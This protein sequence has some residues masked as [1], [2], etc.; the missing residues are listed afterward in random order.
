MLSIKPIQLYP[1]VFIR[2]SIVWVVAIASELI[3]ESDGWQVR[4]RYCLVLI[5]RR[6]NANHKTVGENDGDD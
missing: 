5:V 1:D 6:A 3:V 4:D 2:L